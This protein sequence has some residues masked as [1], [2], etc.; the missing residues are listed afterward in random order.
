ILERIPRLDRYY[1][2]VDIDALD[3]GIAPGTSSPEPDGLSHRQLRDLLRGM[4]G[5]GRILGMDLVET[6]PFLDPIGLTQSLAAS[7]I[8]EFLAAIFG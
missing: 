3:P 7:T 8:L 2:S 1:V 6:N 5:K 4:A